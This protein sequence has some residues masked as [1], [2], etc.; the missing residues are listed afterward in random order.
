MIIADSSVWISL[1]RKDDVEVAARLRSYIQQGLVLVGDIIMLE[2]LQGARD[3]HQ[4]RW[5]EQNFRE[6]SAVSMLSPSLAIKAAANYRTLR[7][8]GI[9]VR[10][11]ID[12]I[13]GTYCIEHGHSLLHA[14]KDYAP[15]AEHLGLK[16]A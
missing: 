3:Y 16:I 14:D 8:R 15:M 7:D 9:T 11:T 4:A 12:M 6:F 1:F 5:I 2:V 10:K 13:I